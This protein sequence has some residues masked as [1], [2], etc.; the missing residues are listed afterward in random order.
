MGRGKSVIEL[1][2]GDTSVV[3]FYRC[4]AAEIIYEE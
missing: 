4:K 2:I 3:G 1:I